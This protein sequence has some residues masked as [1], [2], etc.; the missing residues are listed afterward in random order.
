MAEEKVGNIVA[1]EAESPSRRVIGLMGMTIGLLVI[2]LIL[3]FISLS[4]IGETS[5]VSLSGEKSMSES[6]LPTIQTISREA[7]ALEKMASSIA[8]NLVP[9][10]TIEEGLT[11]EVSSSFKLMLSKISTVIEELQKAQEMLKKLEEKK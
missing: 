5:E 3:S 10:A 7:A 2:N 1:G 6:L 11:R 9:V 8:T 4:R